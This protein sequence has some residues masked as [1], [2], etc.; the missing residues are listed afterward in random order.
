MNNE[1]NIPERIQN[2]MRMYMPIDIVYCVDHGIACRIKNKTHKEELLQFSRK[3]GNVYGKWSDIYNARFRNRTVSYN[4]MP[5]PDSR[6]NKQTKVGSGWDGEGRH[7]PIRYP[8]KCRKTA[9]KRFYKLFPKLKD[10]NTK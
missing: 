8:K 6:D 3:H 2:L 5:K 7:N 4:K 9:W 1:I 10:K